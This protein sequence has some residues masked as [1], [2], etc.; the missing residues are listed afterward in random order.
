MARELA[1]QLLLLPWEKAEHPGK[2]EMDCE[3]IACSIKQQE[4]ID[5]GSRVC[6]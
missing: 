2:Q 6:P 1:A 5:C 4:S 3:R